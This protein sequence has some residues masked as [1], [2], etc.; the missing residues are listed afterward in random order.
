MAD[1]AKPSLVVPK[2]RKILLSTKTRDWSPRDL[3]DLAHA[4]GAAL[5]TSDGAQLR[6]FFATMRDYDP[7]T[8][9]G[10]VRPRTPFLI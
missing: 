9:G 2:V 1:N 5:N 7:D 4:V 6:T 8:R 10:D 3:G